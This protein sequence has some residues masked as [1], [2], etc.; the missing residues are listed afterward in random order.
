MDR[1]GTEADNRREELKPD[2]G[3]DEID[4]SSL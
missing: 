3:G 1:G 2:A 4:K